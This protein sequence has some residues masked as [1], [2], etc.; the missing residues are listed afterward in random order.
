MIINDRFTFTI[1]YVIRYKFNIFLIFYH[2]WHEGEIYVVLVNFRDE[3]YNIDLTYFENV[4]GDLEV[5]VP[6]IQ[7]PKNAGYVNKGNIYIFRSIY[8][9]KIYYGH[10][11]KL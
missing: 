1:S 8:T 4:S 11:N 10:L 6:S 7:S 5:I 2:R 3:S 9:Q